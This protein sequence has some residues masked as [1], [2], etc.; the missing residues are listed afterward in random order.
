MSSVVSDPSFLTAVP[1]A[2]LRE[3]ISHYWLSL[4]NTESV[5]AVWPDGA[6]D[7]VVDIDGASA[8]GWM[9]GTSTARMDVPL[10][11]GNHYLGIRFKPG[12][13]RHFIDAGAEAL[14]DHRERSDGLFRPSLDAVLSDGVMNASAFARLDQLLGSYVTRQGPGRSR[15]DDAIALI[16]ATHGATTVDEAAAAFG[17]SRRQFERTFQQTVGV[18]PKLFASITRFRRAIG[19][20]QRP[21]A[22]LVDI[23]NDVGYVDQSHMTHA[24]NR[25]AGKPPSRLRGDVA[26]LQDPSVPG[27]SE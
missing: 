14:T 16:Q 1:S 26:F 19:L 3:Y 5:H 21:T 23:A 12:K 8:K 4:D 22:S 18:G 17:R 13:A 11:R 20:L 7:L 10:A 9:Y 15:I 2:P 6:I 24:F 25:F 27:S